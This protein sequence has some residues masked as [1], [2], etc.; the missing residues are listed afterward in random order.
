MYGIN[1]ES[2]RIHCEVNVQG[3]FLTYLTPSEWNQVL[4]R[5]LWISIIQC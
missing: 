2:M 5:V 4:E 1:V 3:L